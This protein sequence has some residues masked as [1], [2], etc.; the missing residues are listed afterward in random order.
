MRALLAR[1]ARRDVADKGGATAASLAVKAGHAEVAALL[2]EAASPAATP[3]TPAQP[4]YSF[5][6]AA[7]APAP[8]ASAPPAQ[9]L[10]SCGGNAPASQSSEALPL[11]AFVRAP[12]DAARRV[13][14]PRIGVKP[15]TF[16]D[17]IELRTT[18][19]AL[20]RNLTETSNADPALAPVLLM[21]EEDVERLQG[22]VG[23]APMMAARALMLQFAN[24]SM[25][26]VSGGRRRVAIRRGRL[27]VMSTRAWRGGWGACERVAAFCLD[28]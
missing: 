22:A 11:D 4:L 26:E 10:H 8:T 20:L 23:R 15:E 24:I 9:P 27:R 14:T 12:I 5:G 16:R 18:K 17:I 13:P 3:A 28:V 21:R 6:G 2:E 25:D 1:G 7:A 19:L